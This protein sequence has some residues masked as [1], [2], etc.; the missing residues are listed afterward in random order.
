MLGSS[1]LKDFYKE[2]SEELGIPLELVQQ[3]YEFKC[4]WLRE[5]LKSRK[6]F[7]ILDT[8]HGTYTRN[9][10]EL[11]RTISH[12][13]KRRNQGLPISSE[14]INRLMNEKKELHKFN[15]NRKRKQKNRDLCTA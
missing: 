5:N 11:N 7:R 6:Y 14:V 13:I 15:I 2:V 4:K 1:E 12:L 3:V 9:Y 8:G 10:R